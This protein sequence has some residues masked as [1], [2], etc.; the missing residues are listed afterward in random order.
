MYAA[1]VLVLVGQLV[2]NLWTEVSSSPQSAVLMFMLGRACFTS[3]L[4][5]PLTL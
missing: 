1:H 3:N 4:H 2:A 5:A